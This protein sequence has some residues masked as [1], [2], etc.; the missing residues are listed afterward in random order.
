MK[1]RERIQA[2]LDF[3]KPDR[4]PIIEWAPYW[5][6]TIERWRSEGLPD[7]IQ[8]YTQI[9]EYFGLDPMLDVWIRAKSP[10]C[11]VPSSHG[12]GIVSCEEDYDAILPYLYPKEPY[13]PRAL[14]EIA[15]GCEQGAGLWGWFEGFFWHP[16]E[17]FGIEEHLYA[18]YDHPALMRRMNQDL[19]EFFERTVD[20]I[21]SFVKPQFLALAEDMSYNHGPMISKSIFDE[22]LA[23]FYVKAFGILKA[24]CIKGFV[25]SDGLVD[26]P[27][28]WYAGVG[29]NGFLPL[30]K[31]AGVDLL[32]YRQKH[33]KFLFLGGFD[34]LC[35]NK[36]EN[37]MRTEFERLLPVMRQGG[38][39]LGVDHQTPPEVS[40][41]DYK[42]YI[43][44]LREYSELAA[45]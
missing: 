3:Q 10:G 18:F 42:L 26:E 8:T 15:A 28:D 23:D 24:H 7:N 43:K 45:K 1:S 14:E 12:A 33:P 25:D 37:A 27:V 13:D 34:K 36:G 11:P 16:R 38:Y 32:K 40:I 21:C 9:R 29:C 35:M 2:V 6:K 17:L 39:I 5:D 30:E 4:L 22:Q 31:Q 44:L 19:L 41:E 20:F